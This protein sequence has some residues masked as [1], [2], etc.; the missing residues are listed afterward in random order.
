MK[1][2]EYQEIVIKWSKK[3]PVKKAEDLKKFDVKRTDVL[4]QIYGD[5]H[6]YGR[7]TL[8]YIG[9]SID[10]DRRFNAH[11]NG[12]FDYVN[13][14]SV[15]IGEIEN[16]DKSFE[17]QIPE[18]VLIANHKPSF[19]KDF[20]HDLPPIARKNRIIIINN[21]NNGMLKTCCTNYWWPLIP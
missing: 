10:A 7:D 8:L 17:L 12:V 6:I 11:L 14:L 18:S 3:K 5:H 21:G 4:Y 19:N 1:T 20:I 9:I 2:V 15:S 13:N 16:Y